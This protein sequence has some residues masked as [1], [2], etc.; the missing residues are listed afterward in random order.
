MGVVWLILKIIGITILCI[1]GLVL[2]IL[3]LVLFVPIR[4]RL[5][6][7][8]KSKE[9]HHATVCVHWLLHL[10][11][12][13]IIDDSD[14]KTVS[15]RI[16]IL[17]LFGRKWDSVVFPKPK[18]EDDENEQSD[19][20]IAESTDSEETSE[21]VTPAAAESVSTGAQTVVTPDK[22]DKRTNKKKAEDK[23]K[24]EEKPKDEEKPKTEEK[25]KAEDKPKEDEAEATSDGE[26]AETGAEADKPKKR[27]IGERIEDLKE[28]VSCVLELFSRRKDLAKQYLTKKSTKAAI[29]KLWKTV[30]WLLKHIAPRRGH[31]EVE[32]GLKDPELT[33]KAFTAAASLYPWYG[34]HIDVYP[35]FEGEK[36]EGEGDVR[37]RIRLFGI[38]IRGLSILF[39]KNIK[40]VRKEFTMVKDTMTSTPAEI[41]KIIKKEEAA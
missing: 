9:D 6:G 10:I 38:V 7:N 24:A 18:D 39:D 36:I 23:P 40:K 25:P 19:E 15:K 31:A 32:F 21:N 12:V 29:A 5:T 20:V 26:A 30:K 11:D 27:S 37:G 1:L 3:A 22:K 4:Y 28:T 33:G 13:R 35:Y 41:K 2:L 34:G 8:I 17:G 16:R 14:A